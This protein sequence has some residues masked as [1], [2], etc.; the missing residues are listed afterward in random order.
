MENEIGFF[1]SFLGERREEEKVGEPLEKQ[2]KKIEMR[3]K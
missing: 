2:G 3:E 1:H